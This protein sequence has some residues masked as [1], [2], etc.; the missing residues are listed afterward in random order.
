MV[1][2]GSDTYRPA[3]VFTCCQRIVLVTL[4]GP[5]C[6]AIRDQFALPLSGHGAIHG[7]GFCQV[8]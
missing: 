1:P 3:G 2:Q 7:P 6:K 5:E 4:T 8:C